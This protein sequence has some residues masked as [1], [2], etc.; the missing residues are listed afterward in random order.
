ML[1]VGLVGLATLIRWA[2][3]VWVSASPNFPVFYPAVLIATL[4]GGKRSGVFALI[5]STLVVWWLWLPAMHH[6]PMDRPE[7]VT[8]IMFVITA[9]LMVAVSD[10]ARSSYFR[11]AAADE[12]FRLAHEAS[13]DGFVMLE[14]MRRAGR[15]VDFR[16]V[17]AN[18]AAEGMAPAASRPLVGRTLS[19][20]YPEDA[21]GGLFQRY[22]DILRT[23]KPDKLDFKIMVD[24]AEHWMSSSGVRI[25]DS[26]ALTFRDVTAAMEA[27]RSLEAR[28]EERTRAL[29]QVREERS[30]AEAALAQAQRVETL[31]RLTGGV[32]HDFNNILTVII[33]GLDMILRAV[34]KPER[35]K[36]LA[37]AALAAGRRGERLTRQLL[38]FSRHREIKLEIHKA[39]EI[40]GQIEPMIRRAAGEMITLTVEV[41]P[42][43]GSARFDGA[44]F[45]AALLNLVVNAAHATPPGGSIKVVAS[46]ARMA[47]GEI[48]G[49]KEGRYLKVAVTDTGTGI[50]PEVMQR[51]FEPFFTTKEIGQGSGLGL[52][53]VQG[54]ARQCGGAVTV[55]SP[56]GE[57]AT[58]TVY[59]PAAEGPARELT[60]PPVYVPTQARR[61]TGE[62]VLLVEDDEGVRTLTESLLEECG[63]RVLSAE[64]GPEAL[65]ILKR[66]DQIT[67]MLSDVVMPGGMSGV[68]LAVLAS[69]LRPELPILLATGYAAGRLAE[70]APG[71]DWPVLR[72]PFHLEELAEAIREALAMKGARVA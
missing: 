29:E 31:G 33:G 50:P 12:R 59:L 11:A 1:A 36:R 32:A 7:A 65:A 55:E 52:A 19:E 51:I 14:P 30:K 18:A 16:W 41:A 4:Y 62:T 28:V 45:E 24:G 22:V 15:I 60:I 3:A 58:I 2:A 53:Q 26:V 35:V 43:A 44:Q 66:G 47:P 34:D 17:H 42:N 6:I 27:R 8:A 71:N 61:Q 69:R 63:Y 9:G 23:G 46:R 5:L 64:N 48:E 25:E 13:L 21:A 49:L 68:D 38:A 54:F 67:L 57:G 39:S 10:V 37:E 56:P 20:V 70:L 72:K 40:L